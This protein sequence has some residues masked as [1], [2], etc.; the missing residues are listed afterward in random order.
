MEVWRECLQAQ[1]FTVVDSIG[2]V[3]NLNDFPFTKFKDMI[4]SQMKSWQYQ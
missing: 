3:C 1:R 4:K 2:R